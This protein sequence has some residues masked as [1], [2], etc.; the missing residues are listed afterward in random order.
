[1]ITYGILLVTNL[2]GRLRQ[3]NELEDDADVS[4]FTNQINED[5]RQ[6]TE[7]LSGSRERLEAWLASQ[8]SQG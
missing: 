5:L 4:A 3:L 7:A 1:M 2:L 6:F 8:E